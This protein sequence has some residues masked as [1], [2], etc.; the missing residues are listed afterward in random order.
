[1][2]IDRAVV[3]AKSFPKPVIICI[4]SIRNLPLELHWMPGAPQRSVDIAEMKAKTAM[5]MEMSTEE[6][7]R[8]I[9]AHPEI[10]SILQTN[11]GMT[12]IPGGF[13]IK[14]EDGTVIG[15]LGIS[16]GDALEHDCPIGKYALDFSE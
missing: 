7:Y 12:D 1:M 15:G 13:P 16:G 4:Y 3:K 8:K 9:I 10:A 14:M 11:G 5:L 6:L 2:L